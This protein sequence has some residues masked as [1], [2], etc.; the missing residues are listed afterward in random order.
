MGRIPRAV[1]GFCK[2]GFREYMDNEQAFRGVTE[3]EIRAI[4]AAGSEAGTDGRTVAG[5]AGNA[6]GAYEIIEHRFLADYHTDSYVLRHRKS[7]ARIALLPNE[8]NNKVFFTAFRTPPTDSTGVA[9]IIEHTVLCGSRDFPIKDPFI[10]AAKGSLNTFLNAMTYPDKTV[11]PVA[12]TNEKDFC[13]LMH[14][15]LDA[16]F[17]PNIYT[18]ENIF[19]QEG[20]HYEATEEP[21]ALKVN[22]VV[23]NEMKGVMSNPDDILGDKVMASL[24]PDTTYSIV[25]G[26]DPAVIPDLTYEDYL[27][28]HARYYHPS[29][30]YIYLYGNMDM[31]ER[32]TWLDAAYLSDYDV[33]AVDSAINTQA[34][35]AAPVEATYPYA[36]EA[37]E[38]TS[39]ATYISYNAYIPVDGDPK[40]NLAFKILDYVLCDAEGAPVKEAVRKAGIGQECSSLYESGVRQPFYSI[41]AKYA[42]P[43]QRNQFVDIIDAKLCELADGGIDEKSLL[44]GINYYEFQYR[45]ADFGM[46]PKGL[47]LGLDVMDTWL[48]DENSVW[49][50]LEVG[51]YFD[52]FKEDVRKGYFE[53][54]LREVLIDNP[55]KSVVML[56]P[57]PGL[58]AEMEAAQAAHLEEIAASMTE[59]ERQAVREAEASLRAWQETPDT[60]EAMATIPVL[61]RADLDPEERPVQ[62][63]VLAAGDV[64]VLAHP[65]FTSGID[66]VTFLFD[67]THIPAELYETLGL[68][69]TLL[70]TLDTTR[71]SYAELDHEINIVT[72]GIGQSVATYTNAENPADY[73]VTFE[74]HTK[75][76]HGNVDA[77]LELVREILQQTQFTDLVRIR[78]VLEEERSGVKADLAASGHSTAAGRAASYYSPSAR[79]GDDLSGVGYYRTLDA[80]LNQGID[81][82]FAERMAQTAAWIF[83]KENLMVDITEEES[84]VREML[85]QFAAFAESL[86]GDGAG[87]GNALSAT[88]EVASAASAT[89]SLSTVMT[90][91]ATPAVSSAGADKVPYV[92][93]YEPR[94]EGLTTAGQIQFVCRA[95]NYLAHGLQYTGAL[96][97]L[98]VIEAYDYLWRNIRMK[99]GAYGCMSGF[100]RDGS[101]YFVTYRDPHLAQSI[102]VFEEAADYIRSF[103][104]DE[105]TMTKYVIGAISTI[106]RPMTP[107]MF[108]RYGLTVYMTGLTDEM[109]RKARAEVL[110]CTTEDI[111]KC[112]EIIEAFMSDGNLCVIGNGDKIREH[113]ELFKNIEPLC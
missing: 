58:T 20:W 17:H 38:D 3:E 11:Y 98:K 67:V 77:A 74:V 42:R 49:T 97:V 10:E 85:P 51:S 70:G 33:L 24:F 65:I 102:G 73:K 75:V 107:N 86:G 46:Y 106:D 66:Y 96:R 19:R 8:D 87:A 60:E 2:V 40:R 113:G 105:T 28:F 110:G 54:L 64:K 94:N 83:R 78:E 47:V 61:S 32:L 80:L 25:S 21:F 90:T 22:G 50:N 29:N 34:P 100:N 108:G 93:E 44:A 1:R 48:Y 84:V 101:A 45:E 111:R 68:F 81:A 57:Q 104:A 37:G 79:I 52:E 59:E 4:G 72:G 35:F 12:S 9:H 89:V 13:N 16:V 43:D 23:Y 7:G 55:H 71:Y 27:A 26:G 18:N 56:E 62:N 30:S 53:Q 31:V 39:D 69:K 41:T 91:S 82:T 36:V 103:E 76:M 63:L 88:A 112:A 95:G 14:I 5:A 92:T 109:R 99:G 15:Y 6:I